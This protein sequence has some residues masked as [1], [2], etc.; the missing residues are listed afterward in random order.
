MRGH[1]SR[2]PQE[3]Q[4]QTARTLCDGDALTFLGKAKYA[5]ASL[6]APHSLTL[7]CVGV[8]VDGSP[9]GEPPG[10]QCQLITAVSL[11]ASDLA[12]LCLSFLICKVGTDPAATS[13]DPEI[14]GKAPGISQ[15]F[16]MLSPIII[17]INAIY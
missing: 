6:Q 8:R 7:V 13:K 4:E 10:G 5:A 15:A 11:W 17:I 3:P 16:E 12:S 1:L 14:E 2:A 9:S